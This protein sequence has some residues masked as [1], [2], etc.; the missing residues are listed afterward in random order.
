M[1]FV[2]P[3]KTFRQQA[4]R[5]QRLHAGYWDLAD[6]L[7]TN[8]KDARRV[9]LMNVAGAIGHDEAILRLMSFIKDGGGE[10]VIAAGLGLREPQYINNVAS[11]LMRGGRLH[12]LVEAQFQ[13]EAL[14]A[15]VLTA[16]GK[17]FR[18]T[19]YDKA[20]QL[21]SFAGVADTDHKLTLLQV[22]A[23]M[24]NSMHANGI[25]HGHQGASH[26]FTIEGITFDFEHGKPVR[27]GGVIHIETALRSSLEITKEV[28]TSV[29]VQALGFVPEA[30]S[31]TLPD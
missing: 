22:P 5:L 17:P 26:S 24:R 21:L 25:H 19:F 14:F 18:P 23:W 1:T 6:S 31:A 3:D 30:Y 16:A 9:N 27:C 15:S 28:F 11:D 10:Q 29:P 4:D 2:D 13:L 8:P 7:A 12:M 20:K